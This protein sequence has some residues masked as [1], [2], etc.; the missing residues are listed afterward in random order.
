MVSKPVY[1]PLY[2]TSCSCVNSF[3]MDLSALPPPI[4][5][6]VRGLGK[7]AEAAVR[8]A[9]AHDIA[10]AAEQLLAR[11]ETPGPPVRGRVKRPGTL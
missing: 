3:A 7:S 1:S 9:E 2:L 11:R 5:R 10:A 4:S 8:Q 6:G